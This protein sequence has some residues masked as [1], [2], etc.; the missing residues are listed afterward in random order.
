MKSTTLSLS[1]LAFLTLAAPAFAGPD[2]PAPTSPATPT[3]RCQPATPTTTDA[4]RP[5]DVVIC[6]DTSGS[7]QQLIDACRRKLWDLCSVLAQA[8]PA[9]RLRVALLSYG[10]VH[11]PGD[12]FVVEHVPLTEDL[13]RVYEELMK[14]STNGG[15]EYVGGVLRRA[16]DRLAWS[17]ER[18]ALK[19]VFVAGNESA[20]Q[21]GALPVREVCKDALQRSVVVHAI[22]CGPDGATGDAETWRQV[23]EHGGGSYAAIDTSGTLSIETPHDAE[24]VRLSEALNATYLPFGAAGERAWANQARQD[25]NAG[26]LGASTAASRA[27]TKASGVYCNG[28]WDLID[29]TADAGFKLE[30]VEAEA[31]PE[32]LRGKSIAEQRAVIEGLRARRT[33]LQ[34]Q[35]KAIGQRRQAF[36]A[37][38]L[39]TQ[40]GAERSIDTAMARAIRAQAEAIGFS[41]E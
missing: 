32:A 24:L 22:Y 38:A 20:D 36:L 41:F 7:M 33:A 9:P 29:A 30:E 11:N 14:L 27:Q 13:D 4:S 3:T 15:T 21:D 18:G 16:L 40:Q 19:L 39:A 10:G 37:E 25:A 35:I 23:A 17:Q 1:L 2:D 31:L 6:L 5:V 34:A 12:G 28:A 8:R 26:S